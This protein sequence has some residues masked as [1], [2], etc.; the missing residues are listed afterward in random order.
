MSQRWWHK[1]FFTLI[2][3]TRILINNFSRRGHCWEDPRT[4]GWGLNTFL[5]NRLH[6]KSKRSSY[7]L[8][9]LSLTQASRAP[10]REVSLEPF[11]PP[12]RV[13]GGDSDQP[14]PFSTFHKPLLL[15]YI[16]GLQGNLKAPITGNLWWWARIRGEG[17]VVAITSTRILADGVHTCIT[18]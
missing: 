15:S 7:M 5:Y 9:T 18:R 3:L 4:Q 6:W 8:I 17:G 12:V 2:P 13:G 10:C 11:F 16:M 1:L 14:S